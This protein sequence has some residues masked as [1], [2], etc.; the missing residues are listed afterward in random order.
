VWGELGH[1]A[2][3]EIAGDRHHVGVERVDASTMASTCR[4][5][6]VGPTCT[7]LICAIVKPL[8]AAGDFQSGKLRFRARLRACAR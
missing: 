7:S 8:R 6:I 1:R 4:P 5:L 2:I 3:D